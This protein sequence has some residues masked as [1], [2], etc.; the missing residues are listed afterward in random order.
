MTISRTG[1]VLL[2]PHSGTTSPMRKTTPIA[3]RKTGPIKLD[4][5]EIPVPGE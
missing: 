3:I 4:L 1:Q 2:M 5:R